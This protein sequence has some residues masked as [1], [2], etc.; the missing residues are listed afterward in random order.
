MKKTNNQIAHASSGSRITQTVGDRGSH[1]V[2]YLI[3]MPILAVGSLLLFELA[4]LDGGITFR[5]R[6]SPPTTDQPSHPPA[7][8]DARVVGE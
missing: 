3:L 2:S 1:N 6:S 4:F 7:L 5:L 8:E